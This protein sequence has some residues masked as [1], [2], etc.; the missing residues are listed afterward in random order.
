MGRTGVISFHWKGEDKAFM[1]RS[2]KMMLIACGLIVVLLA[3]V[4]IPILSETQ[5][6]LT[7]KGAS[8]ML[9]RLADAF[10]RKNAS[11]VVSF[12]ADDAKV[13]GRTLQTMH[14]Y[15]KRAFANT[16]DLDVR[17]TDLRYSRQGETVTLDTF[18][19]AS[20][21]QANSQQPGAELY[22]HPVSFTVKRRAMPHMFG[23]FNT[24][25]WKITNVEAPNIPNLDS[26]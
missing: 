22:H 18:V 16:K 8:E 23:L 19:T 25:E 3:A 11:D 10:Y 21:K 6:Q 12:A 13:A 2:S 4:Y 7:E 5:P 15:L 20:E 26:V 24:Y 9:G 14:D 1:K 17:F